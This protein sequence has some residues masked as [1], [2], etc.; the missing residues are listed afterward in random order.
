MS[1]RAWL[2]IGGCRCNTVPLRTNAGSISAV[3]NPGRYGSLCDI[4]LFFSLWRLQALCGGNATWREGKE[5]GWFRK[6][7]STLDSLPFL[8][9]PLQ[10]YIKW[11]EKQVPKCLVKGLVTRGRL[12]SVCSLQGR[13]AGTPAVSYLILIL[14][15]GKDQK[16]FFVAKVL[17]ILGTKEIEAGFRF[18]V[19]D[20]SGWRLT[21]PVTSPQLPREVLGVFFFRLTIFHLVIYH[22]PF[23]SPFGCQKEK[24]NRGSK[25]RGST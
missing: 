25:L 18:S 9:E 14:S 7:E 5:R 10:G 24:N 12:F 20:F 19:G 13:E 2:S 17:S 1:A 21:F 16:P 23:Y 6:G 8:R 15:Y 22:A 4:L 11:K 3:T